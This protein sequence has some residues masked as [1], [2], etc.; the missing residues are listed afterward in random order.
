MTPG[1]IA[2]LLAR[3]GQRVE[4]R[5]LAGIGVADDGDERERVHC[6]EREDPD[7]AGVLAPD[8]DRHPADPDGDRIAAE[9][10]E[11]QRLDHDAL[12]EAEMPQ[13]AGFGLVER[14][15]VD[16][17]RRAPSSRPASW[18]RLRSFQAGRA[19]SLLRLI[20]I[21]RSGI[22]HKQIPMRPM[23]GLRFNRH[24]CGRFIGSISLRVR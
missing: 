15:P 23:N 16:R 18:S 5:A 22:G 4:Q 10:P 14:G 9:R 21:N 8:R 11:V 7:R 12:V 19:R 24:R 1:I 20:I 17:Q 3:A 6:C 2:D 13:A